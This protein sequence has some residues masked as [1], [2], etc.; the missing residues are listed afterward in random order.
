MKNIILISGF[1]F[2]TFL[3]SGQNIGDASRDSNNGYTKVFDSNNKQISSGYVGGSSDEFNF[4]NCIL[5]VRDPK[6][7]YT[8]VYDEKLKQI[9]S[10]YC[11]GSSDNFNVVG[12]N[13]VVKNPKNGYKKTYDK[14]LKQISSGY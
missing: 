6:N 12:C 13:V 3:S 11:G 5:V 8:K 7:G 14:N 10:G 2:I 1:V 4:S 9:S